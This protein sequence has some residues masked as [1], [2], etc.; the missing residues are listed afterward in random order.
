MRRGVTKSVV[1]IELD[2]V[3][4][5][6][7]RAMISQD[8]SLADWE[9][10]LEDS[11]SSLEAFLCELTLKVEQLMQHDHQRFLSALYHLDVDPRKIVIRSKMFPDKEKARVVA[12]LILLRE[13]EKIKTRARF[14]REFP[15][16]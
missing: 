16:V 2:S 14:S 12:E 10:Q 4:I 9:R 3:A 8:L 13:M 15:K 5:Q 6:D 11:C 7:L 1:E